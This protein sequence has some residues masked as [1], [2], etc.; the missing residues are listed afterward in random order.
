MV[1]IGKHDYQTR[2]PAD[3][4]EQLIEAAGINAAEMARIL[5]GEP[6]AGA[7]AYALAPFIDSPPALAELA[8]Q[9]A[10]ADE[11]G[12]VLAALRKLYASRAAPAPAE[13]PEKKAKP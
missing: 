7:M 9:I 10:A 12:E 4:D 3:L 6:M 8:R 13:T 1:K 2:A 5:D 11:P